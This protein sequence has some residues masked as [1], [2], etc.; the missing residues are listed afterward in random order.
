MVSQAHAKLA[1][2]HASA[3]LLAPLSHRLAGKASSTLLLEA[4]DEEVT[5]PTKW[6]DTTL[7]PGCRASFASMRTVERRGKRKTRLVCSSCRTELAVEPD[8]GRKASFPRI[9]RRRKDAM[10]VDKPS[11]SNDKT[12][13]LPS[14]APTPSPSIPSSRASPAPVQAET[15]PPM[16]LDEKARKKKPNKRKEGLTAMLAARNA[17]EA[18]TTPTSGTGLDAFLKSL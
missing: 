6:A 1:H 16:T 18:K 15:P 17:R 13:S 2:I 10:Q 9:R 5:L 3:S 12:S 8:A 11:T 14:L 4:N 7:C